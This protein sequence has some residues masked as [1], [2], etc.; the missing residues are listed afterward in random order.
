MYHGHFPEYLSVSTAGGQ[1]EGTRIFPGK[2]P[3]TLGEPCLDTL[4]QELG[5]A[6]VRLQTYI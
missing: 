6:R 1:D 3:E 4:R 5:S 2:C